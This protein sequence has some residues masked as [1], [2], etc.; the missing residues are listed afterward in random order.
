[1]AKKIELTKYQQRVYDKIIQG[2]RNDQIAKELDI[3]VKTVKFH[4]TN[5]YRA[6]KVKSCKELIVK[7]LK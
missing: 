7:H 1:M 6:Y 2:K 4:L 3:A 5:I